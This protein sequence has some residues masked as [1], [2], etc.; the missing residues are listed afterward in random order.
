MDWS[1]R[2]N[3]AR[4]LGAVALQNRQNRINKARSLGGWLVLCVREGRAVWGRGGLGVWMGRGGIREG[5][6]LVGAISIK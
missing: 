4:S 5:G 1:I 6:V 2:V 3:E